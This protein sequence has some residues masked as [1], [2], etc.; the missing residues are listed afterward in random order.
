MVLRC[1][2]L[3]RVGRP[4][5][6]WSVNKLARAVTKWTK[7]CDQRLAPLIS[8]IQHTIEHQQHYYVGNTAQQ[9]RLGLFQDWFCRRPWRL[10][11]NIRRN[12]CAFFGSHTCVPISWM[13]KNQTSVSHSSTSAEIISLDAGSRAWAV[14]PLSLSG[15]WWLKY[16]I[17]YRT[18]QMD[19]RESHGENRR[20]LSS[21]TCITPS[22]SSTPTSFQ[23]TLITLYVFW[24]QWGSNQNDC[25]RSKSHN[26]ACFTNPLSCSGLVVW[27]D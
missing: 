1:L 13:C 19:T 12:F 23:Q 17:P 24:G 26:E 20:Q 2:Y 15:I 18:E 4:D 9:C 3:A 6:L 25:Q 16:F 21:Q 7:S 11:I 22:Q 8:Y 5:K 10:K 27:Q 14:F